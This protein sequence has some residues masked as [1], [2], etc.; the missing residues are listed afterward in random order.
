MKLY[1]ADEVDVF[2]K[3]RF[4]MRWQRKKAPPEKSM[5]CE[6]LH[7]NQCYKLNCTCGCHR[8]GM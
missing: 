6:K 7:H 5:P 8:R 4:A 2:R 3:R 1:K